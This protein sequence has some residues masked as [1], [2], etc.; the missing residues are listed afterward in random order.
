MNKIEKHI[1]NAVVSAVAFAML[2][3]TASATPTET[4][5]FLKV[6]INGGDGTTQAGFQGWDI[7]NPPGVNSFTKTFGGVTVVLESDSYN[8]QSAGSRN[9]AGMSGEY[10]ANLLNDFFFCPH[11]STFGWGKDYVALTFSGLAA[12]TNYEITVWNYDEND[13]RQVNFMAWGVVN[14]RSNPQYQP[15][16]GGGGLT[17]KLARVPMTGLWPSDVSNDTNVQE[18]VY[19]GSFYVTTDGSGSAQIFGWNDSDVYEQTAALVDGFMIG[20]PSANSSEPWQIGPS[21]NVVTTINNPVPARYGPPT[22]WPYTTG[23][24]SIPTDVGGYTDQLF[25]GSTNMLGE[26]FQPPRDFILRNFYIACQGTANSGH[27]NLVLYDLDTGSAPASFNPSIYT[28]L[29]SHPNNSQPQY[30]SFS[31][32]GLTNKTVVKFKLNSPTDQVYLTNCHNYFLG[33]QFTGNGSNDLIWE[34]T[35]SG[36]TYT[37]GAAYEGHTTSVA[38]DVGGGNRNFV[39]AADVLNPNP[40]IG[41]TNAALDT[42]WPALPGA[43]TPAIETF[44]D[45]ETMDGEDIYGTEE[46]D[47]ALINGE[48]YSMSFIATSNFNLGSIVLSQNGMGSSNVLFTVGI[49][50]ITNTF[51]TATGSLSVVLNWPIGFQPNTDTS[52]KGIPVFGTNVDFYYT[53]DNGV[54]GA[55][56]G[57][58]NQFLILSFPPAYQVPLISN[59]V[60]AI[61]ISADT[62]GENANAEDL[63]NWICNMTTST[64]QIGLF[65]DV[66]GGPGYRTNSASAN[67]YY[68][69]VPRML[70]RMFPDPEN[71]V[72]DVVGGSGPSATR[73][74]V[75]AVYAAPPANSITIT[76]ASRSG[77]SF[78]LAW[79]SNTGGTYSVLRKT[80]LLNSSWT[81][82]KSGLMSPTYTDTTA[83]ATTGFYKVSSP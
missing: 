77:N 36:R 19:S 58:D 73:T 7:A 8:N 68:Y 40:V 18:F 72:G 37:N 49:W 51:F 50:D 52:P 63:F 80:N 67:T 61:E 30:W 79:F 31:P 48:A 16:A 32:N 42:V 23:G 78:I 69:V 66:G 81:L 71:F 33:F 2:C 17:P 28:N 70:Y 45:P 21:T 26:T 44:A 60:Y 35:T 83:S 59:H 5:Q 53:A 64:F 82:L 62:V 24:L 3:H 75:M 74:A 11:D 47:M 10:W 34:R 55:G 20:G 22:L 14:P 27:Y 15:V 9:R 76:S 13:Q 1:L 57:Y 29:L 65:P 38:N 56:E 12:N 54:N 6:D 46:A 4:N 41:V 25:G 39:M 43:P